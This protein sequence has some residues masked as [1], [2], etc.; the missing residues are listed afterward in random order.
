MS[1]GGVVAIAYAARHPERVSH[2][3]LVGAY[4]RGAL[5]RAAS[6]LER[7][8][9]DTLV[10]L[11]RV[12][13]G[14]DNDAF[15]QVFTNQFIPGG[16][17]EQ[18]RWWNEL[19]RISAE[20]GRRGAHA[21]G[22]ST[23]STSPTLA[24]G[25]RVPTLV[26]ACA[27]RRA[28]AVRRGP[29]PRRADSRRALRAARERQPC[30]ARRRA[31]VARCSVEELDAFLARGGAG[32][33]ARR[34]DA[35]LHAARARRCSS[36]SRAASTT[37]RSRA[38]RQEREDGAQPGLD[39]S[40]TSSACERA[41]RRSCGARCGFGARA[42]LT[43]GPQSRRARRRMPA[44]FGTGASCARGRRARMIASRRSRRSIPKGHAMQA[45]H[46]HAGRQPA[47]RQVHRSLQ[48]HPL[49]HRPRRHPRPRASTSAQ[50]FLPD[51]LSLVDELAFLSAGAS[52]A[53]SSQVQGRT[54]ANMFGLVERFIGA[55]MLEVSRDHCARRPDR[56]RGA[57]PLHRRGAEAPGAVPPRRGA[58]RPPACRP[59]TASLPQ[60]ND[61]AGVRARQVHL[62]GARR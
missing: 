42:A 7:L 10:N 50:K 47:L 60:P 58:D 48:A 15:R 56:A 33:A 2:L 29:P 3:V 53:S 6:E 30:P 35:A 39:A 26:A 38:A 23:T 11:I 9:A 21:R 51:G 18:H 55:K 5:R 52:S 31:G 61:V 40:S 1:Q 57:R 25:L 8:E 34:R 41:P 45:T 62:G 17:A 22:A 19:E 44:R 4:A 54:Y 27:P 32:R 37:T 46:L 16:T 14:R 28:R 59:A 49:G 12:G 36:C 24:A 20:P 43:A 13:W